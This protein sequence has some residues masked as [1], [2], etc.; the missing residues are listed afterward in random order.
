MKKKKFECFEIDC[1]LKK[2]KVNERNRVFVTNTP[3]I[4]M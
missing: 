4:R 1:F 3:K 2:L